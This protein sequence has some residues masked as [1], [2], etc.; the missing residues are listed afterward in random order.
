MASAAAPFIA[1]AYECCSTRLWFSTLCFSSLFF[2][3]C[4][5]SFRRSF[6]SLAFARLRVSSMN[7]W[8]RALYP[9]GQLWVA[10]SKSSGNS[11]SRVRYLAANATPNSTRYYIRFDLGLQ[12][13]MR[14]VTKLISSAII[15]LRPSSLR[16]TASKYMQARTPR[17]RLNLRFVLRC[18]SKVL[19][20]T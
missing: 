13:R 16:F 5:W 11:S 18:I 14:C 4:Y 15:R 17:S 12:T 7:Y 19:E 3:V 20:S 1:V 9:L 10:W 6:K 2:P 8:G